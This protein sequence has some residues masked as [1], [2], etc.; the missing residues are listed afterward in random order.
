MFHSRMAAALIAAAGLIFIG[1]E[2]KNGGDAASSSKLNEGPAEATMQKARIVAA[3]GSAGAVELTPS[4]KPSG[5]IAQNPSSAPTAMAGRPAMPA[6]PPSS[7]APASQPAKQP[8]SAPTGQVAPSDGSIASVI[9]ISEDMKN[10]VRQGS[11]MFVMARQVSPDG[12]RGMAVAAKKV[13]VGSTD[14]F[15]MKFRLSSADVMMQG[16]AFA[17]KMRIEA[18]IDQDGDAISKQ[19]GDVTGQTN[20]LIEVGQQDVEFYLDSKI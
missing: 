9:H 1:C 6:R 10:A 8:T 3:P 20:G 4:E 12:G 13:P 2:K 5:A 11:V 15:P 7:A 16:A 19:P 18:R 17:G 14:Q